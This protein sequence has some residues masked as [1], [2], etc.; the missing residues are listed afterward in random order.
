MDYDEPDG[1]AAHAAIVLRWRLRALAAGQTAA[2]DLLHAQLGTRRGLA[3]ILDQAEVRLHFMAALLADVA[4]TN[5]DKGGHDAT[6]PPAAPEA[7]EVR[8]ASHSDTGR[9]RATMK[10]HQRAAVLAYLDALLSVVADCSSL[11]RHAPSPTLGRE[12][13]RF[14]ADFG[15]VRAATVTG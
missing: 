7:D 11:D 4:W 12:A 14:I 13:R 3:T 10:P 5:G 15:K 2:C 1:T 6:W 9:R 8:R